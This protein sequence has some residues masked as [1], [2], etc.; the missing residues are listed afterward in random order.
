MR[1]CQLSTLNTLLAVRF[2]SKFSSTVLTLMLPLDVAFAY[3]YRVPLEE[4]DVI[5]VCVLYSCMGF[6]ALLMNMVTNIS[7]IS[8]LTSSTDASCERPALI[9]AILLSVVGIA[10]QFFL[11]KEK[12]LVAILIGFGLCYIGVQIL[13]GA[14][15]SLSAIFLPPVHQQYK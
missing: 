11:A 1:C 6:I 14:A 3:D 10:L 9:G 12:Y 5:L 7:A 2:V 13:D 15:L 8:K 4:Q